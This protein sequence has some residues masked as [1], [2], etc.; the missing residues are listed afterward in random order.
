[1]AYY[2][3]EPIWQK[4]CNFSLIYG[5]RSNGK[6]YGALKKCLEEY[7]KNGDAFAYVRRT[8]E[9]IQSKHG[10]ATLFDSI[11]GN[12][13]VKEL[14]NGKWDGVVYMN[15]CFYFSKTDENGL[16]VKDSEEFC[17]AFAISQ[18]SHYKG[19]PYPNIHNVIFDEFI[20]DTRYL[21]D[22]FV[23]F[24]NLLSTIKRDKDKFRVLMLGNTVNIYNPYF[25]EMGLTRAKDQALHRK[26][27]IDLYEN[28]ETGQ[29]I[30]VEYCAVVVTSETN[31]Q[32]FCFDSPKMN[33]ILNGDWETNSYPHCPMKYR[34]KD[35]L[36]T[37]YVEFT[38]DLLQCEVIQIDESIFTFVHRW[39]SEIDEEKELIFSQ[40]FNPRPNY[41]RNLM[42]P[43]DDLGKRIK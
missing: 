21:V 38:D 17:R 8:Q 10:I 3:I 5:M 37:Y 1:M 2:D 4:N 20:S 34:P 27:S 24:M 29:T 26:G 11:V 16:V 12:G 36:Y 22:E 43:Q 23:R 33:M 39:T 41:R 6:T 30:A 42:K 7:V 9:D 19:N 13:V 15:S 40:K 14:T 31:E 28:K 25:I 32:F 18:A 35:V